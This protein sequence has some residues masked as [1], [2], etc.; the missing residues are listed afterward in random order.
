VGL[1][2]EHLIRAK[3]SLDG[4]SSV[5]D[6]LNEAELLD[7]GE[8]YAIVSTGEGAGKL[9]ESLLRYS[10]SCQSRLADEYDLLTRAVPL[11][12]FFLVAW[13]ILSGL[14]G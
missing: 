9:E 1:R 6:A 13:V 7:P 3:A 12:I 2:R 5:A 11:L 4:G 8:G 10:M 14:L